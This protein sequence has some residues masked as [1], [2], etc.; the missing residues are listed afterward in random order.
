MERAWSQ[1]VLKFFRVLADEIL[2][3]HSFELGV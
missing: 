2:Y 1:G 3:L